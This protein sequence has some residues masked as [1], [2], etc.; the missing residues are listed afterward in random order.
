MVVTP[1]L[2]GIVPDE[3]GRLLTAARRGLEDCDMVVITA[4]SS[5]STRDLT[6]T[7]IQSLG[8]PGVLA[9]GINIRPGKPTI[10]GVCEGKPVIG[11][12][13]NP[14]SAFVVARL[15]V[16]PAISRLL[17]RKVRRTRRRLS[18]PNSR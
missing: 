8:S 9:H 4:G 10:L 7:T 6:A 16:V 15:I 5:A 14:V 18:R 2:L 12:P 13:G 17:G 11:L 1:N 3:P